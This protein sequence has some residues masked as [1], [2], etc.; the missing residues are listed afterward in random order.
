MS[1]NAH[2]E[3]EFA[4]LLAVLCEEIAASSDKL[5]VDIHHGDGVVVVLL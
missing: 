4:E 2:T 3:S 5:I 1:F